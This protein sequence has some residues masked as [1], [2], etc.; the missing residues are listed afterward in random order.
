MCQ[1][2]AQFGQSSQEHNCPVGGGWPDNLP[3]IQG[4][5]LAP[6]STFWPCCMKADRAGGMLWL[7]SA[8]LG[9]LWWEC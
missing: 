1:T 2:F 9:T 7:R 6:L 3:E 5:L 8:P 4:R